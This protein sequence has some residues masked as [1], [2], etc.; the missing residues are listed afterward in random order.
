VDTG[1]KK[2][3]FD[4]SAINALAADP[5]IDA[6]VRGLGLPYYVGITET[7]LAEVIADPDEAERRS[8]LKLLDRLLHPGMPFQWIIEH[9]ASAYEQDK[10]G[11][12]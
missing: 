8:L 2:L 10:D 4:T 5:G 12:E 6:I 9:Q 11:Y 3:I 7:V 1:R